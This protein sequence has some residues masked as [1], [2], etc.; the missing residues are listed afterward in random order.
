[1][2]LT[3]L[4]VQ[5]QL[6]A[7]LKIGDYSTIGAGSVIT[8][9]VQTGDLAIGRQRQINK[10]NRSIIRKE[11]I[12]SIVNSKVLKQAICYNQIHFFSRHHLLFN[13]IS[14]F[15]NPFIFCYYQLF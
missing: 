2:V 9:N 14:I 11:L 15:L 4:L 8:E 12:P 6:V 10:K 13:S 5:T 1:M 3:P 7:P